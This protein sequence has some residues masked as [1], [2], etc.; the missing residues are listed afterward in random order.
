MFPSVKH[1]F[2]KKKN[3]NY[4]NVLDVPRKNVKTHLIYTRENTK[5]HKSSMRRY[6]ILIA[7]TSNYILFI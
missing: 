4:E 2:Q 1:P 5:G 3:S 7:D 6:V